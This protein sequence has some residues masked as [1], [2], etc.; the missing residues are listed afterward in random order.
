MRP[1]VDTRRIRKLNDGEPGKGPVLY[2]MDRDQRVQDNWALLFARE[3]ACQTDGPL[4]V[5]TCL[6]PLPEDSTTRQGRFMI[7]GL[8][9]VEAELAKLEI[10]LHVSTDDAEST[11]SE[12]V[13][14]HDVAAVITDLN[15]LREGQSVRSTLADILS[16]P[17]YEVD[18][19]NI[20][21]VWEASNKLEF[22]AYTIRP[23]IKG[24]LSEF[25]TDFPE[26]KKNPNKWSEKLNQTDWSAIEAEILR[27]AA[28]YDITVVK[29]GTK[30]AFEQLDTYLSD[31]LENYNEK[32]ND[33]MASAQSDL[34]AYLHFGQISAQRVALEAKKA[35]PDNDNLDAFL[36]EL[37][38][39]RELADNF[40][41]YSDNYLTTDAFPNW[42]RESLDKH[43]SDEREYV[44]SLTEF[45]EAATHD[46]LWNAAQRERVHSGKMHGYMR[47]YWAKKILEWTVSPEDALKTAIYLNDKYELDGRDSNGYAGVAWSIGGVH[48]RAFAERDIFGKIRFMSYNGCKRKFD[49]EKYIENTQQFTL[50]V[51]R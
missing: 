41:F 20:V 51:T 29:P 10:P 4:M 38:V 18:A 49:I 31:R 11:L 2:W 23:K 36:E 16:V 26:L 27:N 22:A 34:S 40:C 13:D 45:E 3:M 37:I 35:S 43:R 17:L 44:Y 21:P 14:K 5:V 39:R 50:D 32:R 30:A 47:M 6:K 42:A 8:R 9:E 46:E 28:P 33:P 19:H 24:K 48:D 12:L 15:P 25:L 7:A 1:S